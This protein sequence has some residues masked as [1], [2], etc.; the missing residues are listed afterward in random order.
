MGMARITLNN[1]YGFPLNRGVLTSRPAGMAD[2]Q[3][4]IHALKEGYALLAAETAPASPNAFRKTPRKTDSVKPDSVKPDSVTPAQKLEDTLAAK[5][6][7][8]YV[9]ARQCI[10]T[11]MS[12]I[13]RNTIEKMELGKIPKN[14]TYDEFIRAVTKLGDKLSESN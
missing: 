12:S 3:Y 2:D 10:L 4:L 8:S 14:K 9:R 13:Q 7:N 1:D 6:T 5:S 11:Q